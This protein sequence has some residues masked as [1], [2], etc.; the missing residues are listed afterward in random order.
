VTSQ[1]VK[2]KLEVESASTNCARFDPMTRQTEPKPEAEKELDWKTLKPLDG[3]TELAFK[4]RRNVVRFR[5]EMGIKQEE[6]AAL[7]G[8]SSSYYSKIERGHR[9]LGM[10]KLP[11]FAD[12]F[13]RSAEH[14]LLDD[15]PAGG[16]PRR[17]FYSF[18]TTPGMQTSPDV[19]D[20][21]A[22]Q[23][24]EANRREQEKLREIK[25]RGKGSTK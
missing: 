16:T 15:P 11:E 8:V 20:W 7:V 3:E 24:D 21:L 5:R 13:G 9:P 19:K 23:V 14:F 2:D 12:A 17:P 6:A 1:I 25:K 4:I 18:R 10:K 22:K